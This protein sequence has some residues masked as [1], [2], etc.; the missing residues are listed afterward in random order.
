MHGP[1][2]TDSLSSDALALAESE[3]DP[4]AIMLAL[5]ARHQAIN[6]PDHVAARVPLAERIVEL[7][8]AAGDPNAELWGRLARIDAA[9]ELGE[10]MVLRDNITRVRALA[11]RIGWPLAD[12][13]THRLRAAIALL[14]GDFATTEAETALAR[15]A[16]QRTREPLYTALL[17]L[18]DFQRR[19]HLGQLPEVAPAVAE[20]VA[21]LGGAPVALSNGGALLL[22]AGDPDGALDCYERLR[23]VLPHLPKDGRWFFTVLGAS[24]MAIAFDDTETISWCYRTLLP[25]AELF[26]AGGGGAIICRGSVGRL[27]GLLAD[28]AGDL[29]AAQAH[30]SAAVAADDRIGAVPFRALSQLAMASVLFRLGSS[31]DL[32]RARDLLAS[33]TATARRLRMTPTLTAAAE[34]GD[35]VRR[36][37]QKSV[38]L[39]PRER[40]VLARV[41][42]GASNRS[43][44]AALVVSERTVEYHVANLLTKIGAAN[45]TEAATWA[46]RTGLAPTP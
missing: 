1:A 43:I 33:V 31:A 13:H 22:A 11:D 3:G 34:L 45:R 30:L 26:Q 7:A 16:A 32:T 20:F 15:A 8:T 44:A 39:T 38:S 35:A 37:A 42:E 46:L 5:R 9:F 18:L 6:G 36:A 12:W 40:E 41:A 19:D 24:E 21:H 2:T 14:G 4:K 17:G 28:A 25:Y 27:L 29:P 10:P 23:P